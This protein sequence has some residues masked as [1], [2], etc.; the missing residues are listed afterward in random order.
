MNDPVLAAAFSTHEA[1]RNYAEFAAEPEGTEVL[2]E[3]EWPDDFACAVDGRAIS[4]E[5]AHERLTMFLTRAIRHALSELPK[6]LKG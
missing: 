2:C 6:D 3:V 1:I 5:E 4:V